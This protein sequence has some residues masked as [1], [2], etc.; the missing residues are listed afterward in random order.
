MR[1]GLF[2]VAL[3]CVSG[4]APVLRGPL[5]SAAPEAAAATLDHGYTLLYQVLHDE[6]SVTLLFGIKHAPKSIETLVRRI[7]DAAA[8]GEAAIR[9][10]A[11]R[12][13]P[14]RWDASG[15][16][17]IEVSA[18]HHIAN[19]QAAGLLL[20]G[21]SFEL[22]L[23]LAQQ[24]ACDYISALA[25]TLATADSNAERSAMLTTL[26]H[27]FA[28]FEFEL[29]GYLQVRQSSSSNQGS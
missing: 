14:I 7:G 9:S 12:Y 5:D 16:P 28:A 22:R 20:A 17:L 15:L 26:A 4:C 27:E 3:V 6:S 10:T 11:S 21:D 18:R 25:M 24:K 13:P 19:Q 8:N 1:H 29:R 2:M 23:L